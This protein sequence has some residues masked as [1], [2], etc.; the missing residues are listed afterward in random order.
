MWDAYPCFTTGAPCYLPPN[1]QPYNKY[2]SGVNWTHHYWLQWSYSEISTADTLISRDWFS[3]GSCLLL[4]EPTRGWDGVWPLWLAFLLLAEAR[5][6]Q[7]RINSRGA[8]TFHE[9]KCSLQE[10][11]YC[12]WYISF[13]NGKQFGVHQARKENIT[14]V[15]PM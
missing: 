10:A 15:L 13:V 1:E 12:H 3:D 11:Y 14:N 6:A 2:F 5:H 9:F 8:M 4:A 7:G